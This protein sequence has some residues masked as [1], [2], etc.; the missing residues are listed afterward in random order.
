MGGVIDCHLHI[1]PDD[2]YK[3]S[4]VSYSYNKE[5]GGIFGPDGCFIDGTPIDCI[6]TISKN[7]WEDIDK[8]NL[9][10]TVNVVFEA[11][12]YSIH[13]NVNGAER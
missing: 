3:V 12:N 1:K 9:T 2:G 10:F 13:V 11:I 4:S 7:V 6:A 5:G 8:D